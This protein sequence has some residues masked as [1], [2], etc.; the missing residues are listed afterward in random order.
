MKFLS[1]QL[2]YIQATIQLYFMKLVICN[3]FFKST[4]RLYILINFLYKK[5]VSVHVCLSHEVSLTNLL[6]FYKMINLLY[7]NEFSWLDQI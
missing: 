5:D 2:K 7:L 4:L 3:D 1:N 6:V